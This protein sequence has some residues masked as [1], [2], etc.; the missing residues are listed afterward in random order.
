MRCYHRKT[1]TAVDLEKAPLGS[2]EFFA[3]C[4][5]IGELGKLAGPPKPGTLGLLIAEYKASNAFLDDL[6]SRTQTDYQRCFDYLKPIADTPLHRFDRALVV[7]IRDKARVKHGRRFANYVKAVLSILFAWGA[8]RGYVSANPAEKIK[9]IRRA[10]NAPMANRPWTDE[11]RHAVLEEADQLL[12]GIALMMFTG[13]GPKD[14]LRLPRTFYK[15]G[16]IATCRSK[17]GEPV[18]WPAPEALR[19]I[20]EAAPRHDATTLCAN[21]RGRPWTES[22]FRSS[23]EDVR[24]RLEKEGRIGPGLTLYGLRHTVAV[25]LRELGYDD[26]AIADALGQKNPAMALLYAEGADLKRKMRGVVTDFEAEV[27]RRRT[28]F[29]KPT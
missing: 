27:N 18:F 1:R 22:G 13:L 9:N 24:K 17:T 4:G 11:E 10:K 5:R 12:T 29:V 26:R 7:R 16:E 28:K 20:L 3:E 15:D 14:A 23:W 21:S 25:I 6:A 19:A 2:A 8:E